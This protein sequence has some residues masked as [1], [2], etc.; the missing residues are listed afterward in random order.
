LKFAKCN[1][2][3]L[4][5][6]F[7]NYI[8]ISMVY[9][10][11]NYIMCKKFEKSVTCHHFNYCANIWLN[12]II[13]FFLI[14]HKKFTFDLYLYKFEFYL[15]TTS[16]TS[17]TTTTTTTPSTMLSASSICFF[18]HFFINTFF[19]SLC[20]LSFIIIIFLIKNVWL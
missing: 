14:M 4:I 5:Y 8:F 19:S 2:G 16:T 6:F 1:F 10:I 12:T 18:S 3:I 20:W 15:W 13:F 11:I 17:Q 7:V 9:Y